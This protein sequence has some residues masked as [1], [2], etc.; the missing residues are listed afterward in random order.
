MASAVSSRS[1]SSSGPRVP[2]LQTPSLFECQALVDRIVASTLFCRSARLCEM[3]RYMTRRVLDEAALEIH[4]EEIG[5]RL[6]GRQLDYDKGVDP[7][8]RVQASHLRKRL[9][10]YFESEGSLEPVYLE[11]PKGAYMPV[12]RYRSEMLVC[13]PVPGAAAEAAA[14]GFEKKAERSIAAPLLVGTCVILAVICAWLAIRVR[15][16]VGMSPELPNQ[17]AIQALYSRLFQANARTSMVVADSSF[18]LLQDALGQTVPFELYVARDPAA[19]IK[20]AEQPGKLDPRL[21]HV[22]ELVAYRQYTSLADLILTNKISLLLSP[23]QRSRL[24]IHFARDYNKRAAGSEN[25]ILLGSDRSDP[26]VQLFSR[27]L[28]FQFVEETPGRFTVLDRR[29]GPGEPDRYLLPAMS[30]LIRQGYSVLA[31]VPGISRQSSV[32]VIAGTDMEAT[33]AAGIMATS[34][35]DLAPVLD[36]VWSDKTKPV[37]YFEALL[38]TERFDGAPQHWSVVRA[39]IV[40]Q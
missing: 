30:H 20:N 13:D 15:Q 37:P 17:P 40:T 38:K 2:D 28:D 19:W 12:F 16:R 26:W 18:T 7:I 23:L 10:Q 39:R 4:E 9:A 35:S 25:L 1:I 21:N 3:L 6:F 14:A 34:E 36:R 22:L 24:S 5:T 11:I 27:H 33:E 32:L 29:P 31:L 8:V